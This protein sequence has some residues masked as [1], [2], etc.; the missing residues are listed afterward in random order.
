MRAALITGY[1]RPLELATVADPE[2]PKDGIIMKVRA[3][4]VCRSD[5]HTWM[6]H[7]GDQIALP[8]IPGHEMAGDVLEV[9]PDVTGISPGDRVTVPFGLACGRCHTC[10]DGNHQSCAT[11]VQPSTDF[12][13]SFAEMI[14]LP[15]ANINVVKLPMK[16][17]MPRRPVLAAGLS[18]PSAGWS[19][20][21]RCGPATGSRCMAVAVSACLPS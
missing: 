9:G 5:W 18:P 3:T 8:M 2:L 20:R 19:N 16:S 21:L 1:Q 6:G 4:G 7:Y 11:Q 14:A 12:N 15:R 17:A 13:G 10:L